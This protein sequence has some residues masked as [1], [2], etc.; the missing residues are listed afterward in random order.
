MRADK[1]RAFLGCNSCRVVFHASCSKPCF[2][3]TWVQENIVKLNKFN[4]DD[5]V[6]HGVWFVKFYA[7]QTWI[8]GSKTRQS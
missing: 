2:L 6:K 4:F 5:N 7:P 8:D 3:W 1:D